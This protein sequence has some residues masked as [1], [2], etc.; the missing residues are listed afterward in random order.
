MRQAARNNYALGRL[1][2][3]AMNGTESAYAKHLEQQQ[4][5]GVVLW[6]KFEGVKLRLA[7][8]T[9][10]TVDFAVMTSNNV[11]EMHEV[12]GFMF[13]D[14]NVKLKVAASMYPFIF[15]VIRKGKGGSWQITEI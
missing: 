10:L 5:A 11:M 3:G 7:D 8:K 12:K 2:T 9:F 14:A 15:K 6:Y 4:M 13:D 1:K